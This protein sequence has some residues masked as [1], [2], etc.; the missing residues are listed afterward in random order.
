MECRAHSSLRFVARRLGPAAFALLA[1]H[2]LPAQ[3]LDGVDSLLAIGDTVGALRV[4]EALI[5]ADERD[6][7]ARYRAARIHM[8]LAAATPDSTLS[9]R[10]RAEWDR[11][12]A[13]GYLRQAT[14]VQPDSAKYWMALAELLRTKGGAFA[15]AQVRPYLDSALRVAREHGDPVVA[16]VQYRT[17][18]T[19]FENYE[20]SAHRYL[21]I[22]D[23]IA[24]D[25]LALMDSWQ[26]L[27][28]FLDLAV[29]P[30]SGDPGALD[31]FETEEKLTAA[32][33]VQPSH[34]DAAGLLMVSLGEQGRWAEA[35]DLARR[36]VRAAPDSG[37]A[38]ALRGLALTRLSRWREAQRAFDTALQR[39]TPDQRAPYDNLAP[40]LKSGDEA[41]LAEL[42]P[43]QRAAQRRVYWAVAQPLFASA[44]N[45]PLVE[46]YARLTYVDHRWSDPYRRVRGFETDRGLVY[47]R[48]GPPDV[49]AT[50]GRNRV[51]QINAVQSLE[52][53]RNMMLWAYDAPKLR[54]L[55]ALTPGM[56]RVKFG[57][58]FRAFYE[59]VRN[60]YP[61]RYDNVPVVATLDT[62]ALQVAQ[63]RSASANGTQIAVF[64]TVPVGRMT[65]GVSL[66]DVPMTTT[67][68]V[69]DAHMDDRHRDTHT[70]LVH[71]TDSLHLDRPSWRFELPPQQYLLRVEAALPA[72]ERA[73]RSTAALRV[74]PYTGEGLMLSDVVVADRVAPR[75]STYRRWTDFLVSP[76]A[77]RFAPGAP[78][79]L[80]WEVYNLAP[81]SLGVARYTVEVQLTVREIERPTVAARIIGGVLDAMGVTAEGTDRVAL[82]YHRDVE[83]NADQTQVEYL[84]VDLAS[85]QQASY[86]IT[87]RVTDRATERAVETY[88]R[89]EV[90]D[91]PL[92][93]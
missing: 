6:V 70:D 25:P 40:L 41:R 55:F 87:I 32:L 90:T 50:L 73:A 89:I 19:A 45:E 83:A 63:F 33:E 47:V 5:A 75:D 7:E 20:H 11:D 46:F 43:V 37:R 35:Y 56:S 86:D 44:V 69:R 81:D 58:D 4:C 1:A 61:V 13:E 66:H 49:W 34:V 27:Q 59:E 31:R 67:L 18:R 68:I 57:A 54:F 71:P 12:R 78:I 79:A 16:E 72:V 84:V 17:A 77:G 23:Q 38:W 76:A 53:E 82:R 15:R 28:T 26:Y 64:G 30:D 22:G 48:Y 24:I 65:Q 92:G 51:S 62:L 14:A 42:S 74:R 21:F 2:A 60:V 36:L 52:H 80:L 93:R 85:T 9:L 39:M 10:R 29:K 91:T 88:R 8:L 3:T